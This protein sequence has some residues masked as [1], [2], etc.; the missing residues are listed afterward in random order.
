VHGS[1][2]F[3]AVIAVVVR[4]ESSTRGLVTLRTRP[5]QFH[6]DGIEQ[7]RTDPRFE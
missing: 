1:K 4:E 2:V 7:A 6:P 3:T 5:K